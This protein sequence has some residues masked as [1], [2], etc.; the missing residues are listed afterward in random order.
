MKKA[1][2]AVLLLAAVTGIGFAQK[3]VKPPPL[4]LVTPAR[5]TMTVST[6]RQFITGTT[7][8]SCQ[9]TI[10]GS[11]VKVYSTG[12]FAYAA[13]LKEG[14][15]NFFIKTGNG[16]KTTEQNVLFEY[17]PPAP[18]KPVETFTIEQVTIEPEGDLVLPAG[19]TIKIRVK[20]KPGC[21]LTLNGKYNIPE[22]PVAQTRMAGIYQLVYRLKEEDSLLLEAL[23]LSL[24]KDGTVHAETKTKS[25]Y[26]VLP[27]DA[28]T[29]GRTT[30]AFT[31]VYSGLGEDRLGGTKAGFLDSGVVVQ[32]VGRI[33]NLYKVKFNNSLHVYI[34][35][36]YIQSLPEGTTPPRSLTNNM[37]VTGDSLYDYVQVELFNK[38][39]YLSYQHI[40]PSKIVV[41][42]YGATA[43]TNWLVQYPETLQEIS[44]VYYQQVENNLLRVTIM[45]KHA[46]HWGYYTYYNGNTLVVKVRRQKEDLSLRGMVIG[47]DAGHGGGNMGAAGITGRYEKEFTLAIAKKVKAELLKDGVTVIM[48]R[49][50]DISFENNDRLMMFRKRNPDFAISIH[51]NSAG[52][53]LRVKGTSTYYKLTGFKNLSAAIYKR[54]KETGLP[55]WGN[56]GNFNFF[57]NSATEFPTALVETLFISSPE[58]EEK[59]FSA[60]FQQQM[61]EKIVAGIKDWLAACAKDR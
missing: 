5:A 47:V 46:Q 6:A 13:A 21:R 39:P 8:D 12:A 18:P 31:P 53:P 35:R 9:L 59:V 49:E 57:L 40:G 32:T 14:S 41:D 10:N 20:A 23:S 52:D 19:E 45:L 24:S 60:D 34:P 29:F 25:K 27:A 42:V 33:G 48:T 56:I 30:G 3:G 26:T 38:L 43:N 22:Q 55:G 4:K 28:E 36:E 2:L 11:P 54:M 7:C 50:S 15:N 1:L 44:D 58:E 51:L 37:R 17:V 16:S 61:A